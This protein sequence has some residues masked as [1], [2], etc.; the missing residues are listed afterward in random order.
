MAENHGVL[1]VLNRPRAS[2]TRN[3]S[4]S[5]CSNWITPFGSDVVCGTRDPG[6]AASASSSSSSS[7]VRMLVS[8]RQKNRR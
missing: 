7:A 3:V 4:G 5:R 6:T 1:N 2:S 8:C